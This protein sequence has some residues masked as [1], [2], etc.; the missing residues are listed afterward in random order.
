MLHWG[1]HQM[2]SVLWLLTRGQYNQNASHMAEMFV[3]HQTVAMQTLTGN[4]VTRVDV[5]VFAHNEAHGIE[6]MLQGL[7]CQEA[8][9]LDVRILVLANGCTDDTVQLARTFAHSVGRTKPNITVEAIALTLGGKIQ[10][11]E[12][13]RA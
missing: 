5:G 12:Q 6:R 4:Q 9:G 1:C 2:S 8:P 10:N 13:L 11:R 3:H 7:M